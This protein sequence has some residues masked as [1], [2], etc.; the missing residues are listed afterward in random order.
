MVMEVGIQWISL[1][2]HVILTLLTGVWIVVLIYVAI[3]RSKTKL[4]LTNK[5]LI[6]KVGGLFTSDFL[7]VPLNKI[8]S[9]IVVNSLLGKILSYSSVKIASAS[10]SCD[11]NYVKWGNEFRNTVNAQIEIYEE[12]RI[13]KQATE[14][15]RAM[16]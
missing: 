1:L 4:T 12:E 10:G 13:K 14:M 16:K 6:G 8:S 9:V 2:P 5:R 15:A 11:Y 7:D 3:C